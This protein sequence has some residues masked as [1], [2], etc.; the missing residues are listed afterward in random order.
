MALVICCVLLTDRIRRRMS[1]RLGIELF[2]QFGRKPVLDL[3]QGLFQ[4]G[5]DRV[6]K[7]L[8]FADGCHRRRVGVLHKAIQLF[9][10]AADLLHRKI[11]QIAARTREHDQD[12][13]L[14]GKGLELRLLQNLD[15]SAAAVKLLLRSFIE[16]RTKLRKRC[17][18]AVLS[19]L[20]AQ[21]TRNGPHRFGLRANHRRGSLKGRH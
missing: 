3:S 18:L 14:D 2:L 16:I 9:L 6:V 15:Q 4:I 5:L 8:L 19:K 7:N 12:L 21:R 10:E 17:Q 20:Q 1:M 11:V 13:L